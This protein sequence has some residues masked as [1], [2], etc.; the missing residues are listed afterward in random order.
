MRTGARFKIKNGIIFIELLFCMEGGRQQHNVNLVSDG[1][2]G[3][4]VMEQDFY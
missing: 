3:R 1:R 2:K 4:W